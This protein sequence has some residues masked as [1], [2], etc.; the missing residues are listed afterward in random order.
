MNRNNV[1]NL[2]SRVFTKNIY[3]VETYQEVKRQVFCAVDSITAS[4]FFEGGANGLKP[5]LRFT[6]FFGDY[7]DEEVVEFEGKKFTVYRTYKTSGDKVELYCER[8][9]GND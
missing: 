4:E 2:V 9:I 1:C 7:N 6:L 5:D 8:R 3:G